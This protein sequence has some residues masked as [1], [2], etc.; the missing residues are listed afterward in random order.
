MAKHTGHREEGAT[1]SLTSG[2]FL[3]RRLSLIEFLKFGRVPNPILGLMRGPLAK[4][5]DEKVNAETIETMISFVAREAIR[6][7]PDSITF[8][9]KMMVFQWT[10]LP[11]LD[12][13]PLVTEPSRSWQ[14]YSQAKQWGQR[15]SALI[16]ITDDYVAFCVDE[17]VFVFGVAVEGELASIQRGTSESDELYSHR[18]RMAFLKMLEA[19][20]QIKFA[21]PRIGG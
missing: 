11:A 7:C 9:E 16:G 5:D 14:L 10:I 13:A 1:V 19:E 2:V 6:D 20:D 18:R 17:A 3:V 12:A 15:P 21:S 4:K 8:D